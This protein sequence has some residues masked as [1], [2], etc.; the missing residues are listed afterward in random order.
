M[1]RKELISFKLSLNE[2]LDILLAQFLKE[3]PGY[4]LNAWN[5]SLHDGF[6]NPEAINLVLKKDNP[7]K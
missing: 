3:N 4:S 6:D 1:V 7:P 5:N 2:A